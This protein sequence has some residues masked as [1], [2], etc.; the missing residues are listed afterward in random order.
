[1]RTCYNCGEIGHTKVKYPK[2][3]DKTSQIDQF[4]NMVHISEGQ[5]LSGSRSVVL[6]DEKFKNYEMFK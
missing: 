2:L 4:T 1:M 5:V 6:S 3:Y